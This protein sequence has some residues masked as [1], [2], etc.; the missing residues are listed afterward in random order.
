MAISADFTVNGNANPAEHEVEYGDS[1]SLALTST[2]GATSIEWS[3]VGT[4]HDDVTEPS[5]VAGGSPAGATATF[6]FPSDPGDGAGRAVLVQA[7]VKD[8]TATERLLDR[9][10][11]VHWDIRR[12][13]IGVRGANGA[14]PIC[15][16][17]QL[18]RNATHGWVQMLNNALTGAPTKSWS[19]S[20]TGGGGTKTIDIP[21]PASSTMNITAE[22]KVNSGSNTLEYKRLI[23][24]CAERGPSGNATITGGAETPIF[25]LFTANWS[26]APSVNGSAIRFTLTNNTAN[27]RNARIEIG[28]A[29]GKMP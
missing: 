3:V 18:D 27:S 24:V 6:T 15:V 9:D 16:N 26:F 5:I 22:A 21:L 23:L 28:Y 4:S 19:G 11:G 14:I 2:T 1:V 13:I 29:I 8:S 25:D 17:E 12:A 20:L 10:R 7:M